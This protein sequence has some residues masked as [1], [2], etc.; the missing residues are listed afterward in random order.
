MNVYAIDPAAV[1]AHTASLR[2]DAAALRPLHPPCV[3]DAGPAAGFGAAARAALDAANQRAADLSAEALRL[4]EAMDLAA[5]ATEAVDSAP[6]H[7]LGG[8]L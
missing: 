7:C 6:C 3:P 5:H 8:M 2:G 4:A 1:A